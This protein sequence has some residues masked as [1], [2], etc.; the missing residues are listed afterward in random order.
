MKECWFRVHTSI[1][2]SHKFERLSL[3]ARGL[4]VSVGALVKERGDLQG[5]LIRRDGSPLMVERLAREVGYSTEEVQA[6]L[7]ELMEA[8]LIEQ[9]GDYLR[10][11]DWEEWQVRED[12]R[13]EW[14]EQKRKQ[15]QERNGSEQK[16]EQPSRISSEFRNFPQHSETFLDVPQRSETFRKVPVKNK[17]ESENINALR[18]LNAQGASDVDLEQAKQT[19]AERYRLHGLAPPHGEILA[20]EADAFLRLQEAHGAT[21]RQVLRGA[22]YVMG[23][24][25][26]D[27]VRQQGASF[28]TLYTHWERIAPRLRSTPPAPPPPPPEPIPQCHAPAA[29]WWWREKPTW[30]IPSEVRE[31]IRRLRGGVA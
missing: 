8:G 2:D 13:E 25:Q 23:V 29:D 7:Q 4:W 21:A 18:A 3:A 12:Q 31:T 30:H 20:C 9:D 16:N 22:D 24:Y 26:G 28:R 14:R 11:H 1:L 5:R 6:C 15:K 17:T 10:M 19:V 27:S